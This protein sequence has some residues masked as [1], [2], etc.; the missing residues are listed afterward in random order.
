MAHINVPAVGTLHELHEWGATV[1]YDS[2]SYFV[3]PTDQQGRPDGIGTMF[4]TNYHRRPVEPD[5]VLNVW[6]NGKTV[7]FYVGGIVDRRMAGVGMLWN[8]LDNSMHV[9]HF[10]DNR[11]DGDGVRFNSARER[12]ACGGWTGDDC[13][14]GPVRRDIITQAGEHR[15][16]K[17][18]GQTTQHDAHVERL[19]GPAHYD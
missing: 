7:G 5:F 2:G 8:P 3:G 17:E 12:F 19:E 1:L 16:L 15:R 11:A 6:R 10:L 9:G 18:E 14:K 4:S 13:V